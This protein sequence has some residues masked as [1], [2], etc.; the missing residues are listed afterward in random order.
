MKRLGQMVE[1]KQALAGRTSSGAVT[2]IA[3]KINGTGYSRARFV[4][5]FGVPLAGASFDA[6]IYCGATSGAITSAMT[7]AALV[8]MSSG[9]TSC[10]AIIDTKI[11]TAY[12][13]LAV[14][15]SG[16]QNSNWPVGCV[17]DLYQ[18]I[19]RVNSPTSPVQY[20]QF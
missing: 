9:N 15:G 11:L 2:D 12:P 1:T 16:V 17:V 4:F 18:G 8:T 6:T 7:S 14:S 13:W 3:V 19:N 10:V 5:N 20:V